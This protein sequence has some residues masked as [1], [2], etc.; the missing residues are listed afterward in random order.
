MKIK[1]Y[2]DYSI[3]EDG[4]IVKKCGLVMKSWI[5][6]GYKEIRL[7]KDGKR[8]HFKLHRLLAIHFIE[9][10]RPL[11]ALTVDHID[12][13]KLNNSLQNLRWATKEEQNANRGGR[14]EYSISKGGLYKHKKYYCYRWREDKIKQRKYFK[15][16][17][18]AQAFE[19]DH[20]KTYRLQ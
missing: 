6:R 4:R 3:Y 12:R 14:Y 11:I 2:E 15:T 5:T 7:R 16:L 20:L 19:I 17:E 8:K 18:L 10:T 1:G 13:D 9:N